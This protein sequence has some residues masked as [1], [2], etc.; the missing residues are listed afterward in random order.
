MCATWSAAFPHPVLHIPLMW[1]AGQALQLGSTGNAGR[2]T[3]ARLAMQV[4]SCIAPRVPK[5]APPSLHVVVI[6]CHGFRAFLVS[7]AA[8]SYSTASADRVSSAST[9]T[10]PPSRFCFQ[11]RCHRC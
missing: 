2:L 4:M 11:G 3:P 5:K 8:A 7:R 10:A 9:P 1:N 6:V